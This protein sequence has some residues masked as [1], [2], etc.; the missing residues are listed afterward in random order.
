MLRD[1]RQ[2]SIRMY[3]AVAKLYLSELFFH[4]RR[5]ERVCFCFKRVCDVLFIYQLGA[6]RAAP[7]P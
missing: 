1:S 7:D 5:H 4:F 2:L 6:A 3:L